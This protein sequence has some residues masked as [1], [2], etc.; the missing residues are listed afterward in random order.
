MHTSCCVP[1][2]FQDKDGTR[3]YEGDRVRLY[4]K[5]HAMNCD[6]WGRDLPYDPEFE[7]NSRLPDQIE[8]GLVIYR[9]ERGELVVSCRDGSC[10][11]HMSWGYKREHIKSE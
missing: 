3:Y 4:S 10:D 9:P 7:K 1:I 11:F 5:S 6:G 2:Y 8:E